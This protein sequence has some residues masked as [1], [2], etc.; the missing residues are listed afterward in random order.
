MQQPKPIPYTLGAK[1]IQVVVKGKSYSMD[2]THPTFNKLRDALKKKDWKKVPKLVDVAQTVATESFGHVTVKANKVFYKNEEAH[3]AIAARI[4][5]MIKAGKPVRALVRFMDNLYQNPS[6]LAVKEFYQWLENNDL[7]IT[8]TGCF[9]AYKYVDEN[10]KDTHTH[11]IDNRPGQVILGSRKW[12]DENYRTQCSSGYHVCSKQYG[13]YG[14][15]ALA[16]LINPRDVLSAEGGKVR[17]VNYEILK[18]LGRK[19]EVSFKREGFA[20]LEKKL[21]IEVKKERREM[22]EM[23]IKH[24]TI[25]RDIRKKKLSLKSL[26][27][28]S[29]SRL[30]SLVQRNGLVEPQ[31]V[32]PAHPFPL[33]S[34]RKAAGLT[35]GQV[36][37]EMKTTY[38]KVAILEKSVDVSIEDHDKFVEAVAKLRG[39]IKAVSFPKPVRASA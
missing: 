35:V 1:Y 26:M 28:A 14:S 19:D 39:G 17:V 10:Y 20:E 37:K 16:V 38:K 25:K 32:G 33:M 21:V 31:Q 7:P 13:T 36:A 5:E 2:S 8:D 4:L 18:D 27:K 24:P 12:F 11:T 30:K 23:L 34:A 15:R 6:K 22:L 9:F 3:D 29:F